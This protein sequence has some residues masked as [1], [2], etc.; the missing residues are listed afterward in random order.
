MFGQKK[1]LL[2][3]G[4]Q[5]EGVVMKAWFPSPHNLNV[6]VQVKFPDG[7]TGEFEQYGLWMPK[8]GATNAAEGSV[9]P[10]RYDSA[11]RS[12]ITLDLPLMEQRYEQ[13]KENRTS[14]IAAQ[15]RRKTEHSSGSV[16]AARSGDAPAEASDSVGRLARLAEL[17]ERGAL[18]D[19]EFAAEKAKIIGAS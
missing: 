7:S 11:D 19:A 13:E 14:E 1:K 6:R 18:T 15:L 9:V 4:A 16:G 8:I 12:M 2:S 3:T 5:A 17:H 10:V